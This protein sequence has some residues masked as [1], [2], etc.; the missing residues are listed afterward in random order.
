MGFALRERTYRWGG[1]SAL[2]FS[3]GRAVFYD[4]ARLPTPFRII[5]FIGLGLILLS[6]GYLYTRNREKISKWL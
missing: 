4:L 6:L 1:L 2:A 5:S 3:L